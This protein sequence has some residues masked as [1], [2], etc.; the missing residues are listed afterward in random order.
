MTAWKACIEYTERIY[1]IGTAWSLTDW[2]DGLPNSWTRYCDAVTSEHLLHL[3]RAVCMK[4]LTYWCMRCDIDIMKLQR[5]S[6]LWEHLVSTEQRLLGNATAFGSP[7]TSD[8][9]RTKHKHRNIARLTRKTLEW[10]DYTRSSEAH[11]HLS[12]NS[13]DAWLLEIWSVSTSLRGRAQSKRASSLEMAVWRI[14]TTDNQRKGSL[15]EWSPEVDHLAAR[16][17]IDEVSHHDVPR[18]V[19]PLLERIDFFQ[20]SSSICS[21]LCP[22]AFDESILLRTVKFFLLC[23]SWYVKESHFTSQHPPNHFIP[24]YIVQI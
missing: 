4:S 9:A 2:P 19:S 6:S 3:S 15:Q 24:W 21:T 7:H 8:P 18:P 14:G 5:Y 22:C 11:R 20:F 13:P 16:E 12:Y 10:I 23:N 1:Q 17:D